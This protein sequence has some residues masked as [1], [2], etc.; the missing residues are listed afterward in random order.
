M[1]FERLKAV[2]SVIRQQGTGMEV[3]GA[4]SVCNRMAPACRA[5]IDKYI[6]EGH[7]V[8]DFVRAVLENN[9]ARALAHADDWNRRHLWEYHIYLHNYTP[10]QCHGSAKKVRDW[11]QAHQECREDV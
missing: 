8:G 9:L 5:A 1:T 10:S 4:D 2:I 7:P 3:P 11:F 6:N